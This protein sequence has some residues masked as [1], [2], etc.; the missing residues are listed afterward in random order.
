M[1]KRRKN[2]KAQIK[3]WT[4][5]HTNI[6]NALARFNILTVENL[7]KIST[8]AGKQMSETAFSDMEELK[9]F[10]RETIEYK[11]KFIEIA[12]IDDKSIRT[13]RDISTETTRN[14]Y[15][16][17]SLAHDLEHSNFIFD[18][19]E[20]EDIQKYYKSE[21]E[22]ANLMI[23]NSLDIEVSVTDGAFI[24]DDER[25]NVFIETATQH[26]KDEQRIAHENYASAMNGKFIEN[27]VRIQKID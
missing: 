17:S 16:S 20:I 11:N 18:M 10:R 21:K 3:K 15:N 4:S 22:L 7:K 13:V 27:K 12:I 1:A 8:V 24:Y 6:V 26:Y 5:R 23:N 25:L 19:F 9:Y 14:I 2:H